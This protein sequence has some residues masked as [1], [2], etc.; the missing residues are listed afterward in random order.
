MSPQQVELA[1]KRQRL[2]L[3]CA[4]QRDAFAYRAKAWEPA[5]AAV[6]RVR[7]GVAWLRQHPALPLV[8]LLALLVAR[9]RRA[10]RWAR[11]G[12]FIWLTLRRLAT[13]S[14][15]LPGKR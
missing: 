3:L 13:L 8:A 9:P 10:L 1:L 5:F 2:Q 4:V 7:Q 6:D 14:T 12:W 11:H 15:Q